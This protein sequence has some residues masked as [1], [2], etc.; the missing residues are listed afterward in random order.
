MSRENQRDEENAILKQVSSSF[1]AFMR[2]ITFVLAN[3]DPPDFVG[4]GEGGK[5]IGLELTSWLNCDQTRAA[6]GRE[7]MRADLQKYPGLAESS[8]SGEFLVG[9]RYAA[10][11]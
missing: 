3:P 8:D 5:R 9:C 2:G 6:D 11:G 7:R 1:L 10:V 4:E